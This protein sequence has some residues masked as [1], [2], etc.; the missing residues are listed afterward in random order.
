MNLRPPF[1]NA[2]ISLFID[3]SEKSTVPFEANSF[4][5]RPSKTYEVT[6]YLSITFII[7]F[8]YVFFITVFDNSVPITAKIFFLLLFIVPIFSLFYLL[9]HYYRYKIRF[10][11]DTFY[12]HKISG[13]VI[14][15]NL[16]E[17]QAVN[18]YSNGDVF[19]K[20]ANKNVLIHSTLQG[21]K[22]F[23][24]LILNRNI[25]FERKL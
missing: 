13:R 25:P 19:I 21:F 16:S 15:I 12:I 18:H 2:F 22:T 20:L 7:I 1:I 23:K 6:G 14:K 4:E 17:I 3:S 9:L 24:E 10:S 8:G 11:N 5:L